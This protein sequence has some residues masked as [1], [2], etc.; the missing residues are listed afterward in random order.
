MKTSWKRAEPKNETD[1]SFKKIW[2]LQAPITFTDF[3]GKTRT[4]TEWFRVDARGQE[5]RCDRL[6]SM[7]FIWEAIDGEAPTRPTTVKAAKQLVTAWIAQANAQRTLSPRMAPPSNI[8]DSY[9]Q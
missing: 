1:V 4:V 6:G 5:I 9:Y 2:L 3:S 8:W 7:G